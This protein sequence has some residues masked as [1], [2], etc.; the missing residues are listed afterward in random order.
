LE[1]ISIDSIGQL[2]RYLASGSDDKFIYV[3]GLSMGRPPLLLAIAGV[4]TERTGAP[5][6]MG[7]GVNTPNLEN[8]RCIGTLTGHTA[9]AYLH[10]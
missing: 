1:P 5:I 4:L 7:F 2:C 6:G 8:W 9:G 3:Y 10:I